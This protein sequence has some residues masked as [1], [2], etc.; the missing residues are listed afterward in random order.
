MMTFAAIAYGLVLG[1]LLLLVRQLSLEAKESHVLLLALTEN[2]K[3]QTLLN[4]QFTD[5]INQKENKPCY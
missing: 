1:A 5:A 3:A 4:T 2:V